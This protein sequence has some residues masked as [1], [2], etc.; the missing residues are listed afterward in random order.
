MSQAIDMTE[1][2]YR[3]ACL[4]A[5]LRRDNLSISYRDEILQLARAIN[6][7]TYA[8]S[9]VLLS[10]LRRGKTVNAAKLIRSWIETRKNVVDQGTPAY[11]LPIHQL[12]YQNR[13]VDRYNRD[14]VLQGVIRT[15]CYTDFLVMDGVFSYITQNDDLLLQSIYDS[16]QHSGKTTVV[17]TSIV[18]PTDCAGNILYRIARDANIK[19]VF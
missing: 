18:D 10:G 5:G 17:T 15:A 13:S 9:I 6:D 4:P 3:R 11:F 14:E 2:Y 8:H 7:G 12:C 19:V 1:T 16:R